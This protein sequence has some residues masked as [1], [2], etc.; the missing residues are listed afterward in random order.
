MWSVFDRNTQFSQVATKF[1]DAIVVALNGIRGEL[2]QATSQSLGFSH[3]TGSNTRSF[4]V[5]NVL[6]FDGKDF[7]VLVKLLGTYAK[8]QF[9][10]Y[11]FG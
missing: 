1:L 9:R 11:V 10:Y 3:L 7:T 6:Y 2:L 4:L 8:I 5:E